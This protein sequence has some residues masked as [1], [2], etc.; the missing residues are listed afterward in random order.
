MFTSFGETGYAKAAMSMAAYSVSDRCE[1]VTETRVL[2]TDEAAPASLLALL[3]GHPAW[4][5]NH[6]PTL[7]A[8]GEEAER[9]AADSRVVTGPVTAMPFIRCRTLD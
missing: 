8:R 6:P 7:A 2:A 4:E 5:R 3:A 1:L 9:S